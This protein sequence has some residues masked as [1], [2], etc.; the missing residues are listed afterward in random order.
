[1]SKSIFKFFTKNLSSFTLLEHNM[2]LQKG[3]TN[4]VQHYLKTRSALAEVKSKFKDFRN[5][6]FIEDVISNYYSIKE[7]VN[8]KDYAQIMKTCSFSIYEA[9]KKAENNDSSNPFDLYD[10]VAKC[11]I[12]GARV[13]KL[14]KTKTNPYKIWYQV[15]LN[16]VVREDKSG[17]K[18]Q[19][20]VVERREIDD[21]KDDWRICHIS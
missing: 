8:H 20:I 9:I 14:D 10:H 17:F 16:L 7:A 21:N 18:D 5:F 4:K 2:H 12:V 3:I 11:D 19:L 6:I 1:M 15:T 13:V